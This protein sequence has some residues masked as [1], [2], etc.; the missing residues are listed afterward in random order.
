MGVQDGGYPVP[1]RQESPLATKG[2]DARSEFERLETEH[3]EPGCATAPRSCVDKSQMLFTPEDI[4]L[5]SFLPRWLELAERALVPVGIFVERDDGIK[6]LQVDVVETVM[7]AETLHRVLHQESEDE[8][9]IVQRLFAAIGEDALNYRE[10]RR[11]RSVLKQGYGPTL[12]NRL[13]RLIAELTDPVEHYLVGVDNA[14]HWAKVAAAI[15]NALTHGLPAK[16]GL[17]TDTKALVAVKEV[18]RR[19][20]ELSLAVSCGLPAGETLAGRLH[21]IHRYQSAANQQL[22]SWAE[23]ASRIGDSQ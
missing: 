1:R 13:R 22:V 10:R 7:A 5:S 12:E 4:E 15:R 11:L 18:T 20:I 21:G 19:V 14:D 2:I 23:L 16:H 9:E 6:D 17:H 3:L 8:P